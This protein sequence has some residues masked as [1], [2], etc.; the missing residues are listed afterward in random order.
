[1]IFNEMLCPIESGGSRETTIQMKLKNKAQIEEWLENGEITEVLE[2]L[3][4]QLKASKTGQ[5]LYAD[6]MVLSAQWK[7][8]N[9]DKIKRVVSYEQEN[10]AM[11]DFRAN[12]VD[13]IKTVEEHDGAEAAPVLPPQKEK[14]D[15]RKGGFAWWWLLVPA[16]LGLVWYFFPKKKDP[17]PISICT[18]NQMSNSGHCCMEDLPRIS[19]FESNS[20]IYV[21][22]PLSD[23]YGPDPII[24][25]VVFWESGEP[26]PTQPIRFEFD[27]TIN[28]LCH[29]AMVRPVNGTA[30]SVGKFKFQ[31]QLNSEVAAEKIFEIVR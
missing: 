13:F 7:K 11:N 30:W 8:L 25:A 28:D 27:A 2:S 17:V 9:A 5:D 14:A 22:T 18:L 15:D 29:V 3:K 21:T 31:L 1:M 23:D 12:L 10:V 19:I 16:G 20:T 4:K 26:F 6:A 24:Q